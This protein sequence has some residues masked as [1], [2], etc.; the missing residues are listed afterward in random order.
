MRDDENSRPAF[1]GP[2]V[3]GKRLVHELI[4]PMLS[5]PD[6]AGDIKID[7]VLDHYQ[8]NEARFFEVVEYI[9]V[10]CPPVRAGSVDLLKK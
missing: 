5:T 9:R 1:P 8:E 7:F 2:G 4:I 3:P 10:M 6:W